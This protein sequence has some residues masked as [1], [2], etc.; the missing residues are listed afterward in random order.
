M[1]LKN[2]KSRISSLLLPLLV[3]LNS[4]SQSVFK[5]KIDS[6]FQEILNCKLEKKNLNILEQ[7]KKSLIYISNINCIGCVNYFTKKKDNYT[8]L[9]LI[10]NKSLLEAK[11]AIITYNLNENSCYF[12]ERKNIKLINKELTE[13][14]SP[15]AF[16][17]LDGFYYF[18][19]DNLKSATGDY[20]IGYKKAKKNIEKLIK[21]VD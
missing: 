3:T 17:Y 6:V 21:A 11:K 18:D 10:E 9:F 5:L 1:E 16:I 12:V 15:C 13:K 19:Y 7:N 8:F 20:A 14:P 2:T 4:F